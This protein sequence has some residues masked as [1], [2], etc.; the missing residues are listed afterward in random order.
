MSGI[1]IHIPFCSK[2]CTYCNFHFSTQLKYVDDV[3]QAILFEIKLREDEIKNQPIETIY[4]G[5]GTPSL[6]DSKWIAEI[7]STL[8]KAGAI[9]SQTIEITLE[10][11]PEDIQFQKLKD[12]KNIGI[13]RFSIGVQS[14]F[15]EELKWM[16]RA[17]NK[18]D[19]D[20]AIALIRE[21]NFSVFS[22]DLIYGSPF[23]SLENWE[24][25]LNWAFESGA[26]HIS[27]YAL[28]VEEKTALHKMIEKNVSFAPNDNLTADSFLMLDKKATEKNWQFYEISNLCF[29]TNYAQHNTNY[30]KNKDYIGIGPAAHSYNSQLKKRRWNIANNA[31]YAKNCRNNQAFFEQEILGEK[32]LANEFILT[33]IRTQWGLNIAQLQQIFEPLSLQQKRS[34]DWVLK[35][36]WGSLIEQNTLVLNTQ[37]RLLADQITSSLFF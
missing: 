23:S 5:G 3:L 19:I 30:W 24:T 11:N 37:G 36:N 1:Y 12:W 22:V 13:N 34:L 6:I 15:D 17:H 33:Q 32:E 8:F 10:A 7:V 25:T 14:L 21:E 28:T 9:V 26:N 35:N 20:K 16:N 31:V 29:E 18:A 2:A 27:A 4:F